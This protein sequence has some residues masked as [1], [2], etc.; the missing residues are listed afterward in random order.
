VDGIGVNTLKVKVCGI[1]LPQ[2]LAC[3]VSYS[4]WAVGVVIYPPSPRSIT[5]QQL[6]ALSV[7][8]RG[9]V[10]LI[11]VLV[12][13]SL[14]Q[15][16]EVV[17]LGIDG[18]QLHGDE[19]PAFCNSLK[20]RHPHLT[21]IKAISAESISVVQ[22]AYEYDNS[23]SYLLFDTPTPKRGGSGAVFD[24]ELLKYYTGTKGFFLSGGIKIDLID[25]IFSF[26]HPQLIGFDISSGVEASP[27][28]KD[29]ESVRRLFEAVIKNT[30]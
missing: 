12:N 6:E 15:V 3:V 28:V 16:D 13:P 9:A 10:A 5:T 26:I 23:V 11:A 21:L 2:D 27:G 14:N 25:E 19:S 30:R 4:P 29:S 17:R 8:P 24:W 7:I 22:K 18:V 20:E 1:S